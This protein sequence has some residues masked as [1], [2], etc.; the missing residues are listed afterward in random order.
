MGKYNFEKFIKIY[1]A[2]LIHPGYS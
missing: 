2:S 1:V